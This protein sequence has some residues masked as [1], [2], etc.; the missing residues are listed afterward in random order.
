MKLMRFFGDLLAI[1]LMT[2]SLALVLMAPLYLLVN[3]LGGFE[4]AA[5]VTEYAP[6]PWFAWA[7]AGGAGFILAIVMR[8]IRV[9]G[10]FVFALILGAGIQ[11]GF[12]FLLAMAREAGMAESLLPWEMEYLYVQIIS[13]AFYVVA[14]VLSLLIRRSRKR[15]RDASRQIPAVSSK[16]GFYGD[17]NAQKQERYV[18]DPWGNLILEDDYNRRMN[19][20]RNKKLSK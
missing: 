14:V 20:V 4:W 12:Y 13:A 10:K 6:E 2:V 8:F 19:D 3:W 15:A 17:G 11:A 9:K 5:F 1:A 18:R 16:D 7:V